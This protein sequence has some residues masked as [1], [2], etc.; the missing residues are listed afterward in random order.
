MKITL[1]ILTIIPTLQTFTQIDRMWLCPVTEYVID[2]AYPDKI[3][4][5]VV[6]NMFM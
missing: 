6:S 2:G 5:E 4:M 3:W 1:S